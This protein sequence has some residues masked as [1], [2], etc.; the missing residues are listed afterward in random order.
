MRFFLLLCL[1]TYIQKSNTNENNVNIKIQQGELAGKIE[2][3]LFKNVE[4]YSFRG[5]PYALPPTE[6]LRFKVGL[7]YFIKLLSFNLQ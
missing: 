4:Y 6:E 3:T 5:I 7:K 2:R 1:I